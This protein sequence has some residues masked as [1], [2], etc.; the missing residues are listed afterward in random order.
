VK[1][2]TSL[3]SANVKSFLRDRMGLFWTVFFPVFFI[4][5]FGTVF[6]GADGSGGVK[7][8]LGV[9]L[10][11]Q[12]PMAQQI[13]GA[14]KQVDMLEVYNGNMDTEM[15]ALKD[16]KRAAVIVIPDN[17]VASI[18]SNQKANL[19]VY[20]DPAQT[21]SSQIVLTVLD[22]VV[23]HIDQEITKRPVVL[24]LEQKT[25]QTQH[26]RNIDFFVPGILAMALMQLG[27][28]AAYPVISLR[29]KGVLKRLGATPLRRSHFISAHVLV[30][31]MI[32]ALQT[33]IIILLGRLV[34]GVQMTGNWFMLAGVVFLGA[35]TFV[36]IG[37]LAASFAK[38]EEA[39]NMLL[40]LINF[41]MMF[42]SGIFFPVDM[43]PS[44][45]KPVVEAMPL[46]YLGDALRQIMTS[47]SSMHPMWINLAVLSG[48]LVV[49]FG[50]SV[51][52]FRWD[53]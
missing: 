53:N 8:S 14:F 28:F 45:M 2:F 1:A 4:L 22:K 40:Q 25:L 43:M 13:A 10:E 19:Q 44:F 9:V 50:I 48:W 27:V 49:T 38:T 21:T 32:A 30:R 52:A 16:G 51:K 20:Y 11:D 29:V 33:A 3:V 47:S 41:P 37:F 46:T 34:F 6:S 36:S 12:N 24:A 7:Y 35:L 31:I 42:L 15:A 26:F 23:Q 18:G 39:G 5:I 17:T